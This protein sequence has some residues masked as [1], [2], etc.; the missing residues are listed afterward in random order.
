MLIHNP[1]SDVNDNRPE[2]T[3][4]DNYKPKVEENKASGTIVLTV[5]RQHARG[6][7]NPDLKPKALPPPP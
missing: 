2:F 7:S 3:D 5:R 6:P 1:S 4:C